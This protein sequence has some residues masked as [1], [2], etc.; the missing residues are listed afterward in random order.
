[1]LGVRPSRVF[2]LV[3]ILAP[4]LSAA[5]WRMYLGDLL[6]TSNNSAE[7]Q[8]T[9]ANISQLQPI[10]KNN[11]GNVISS[12]VT[13]A[14]G[15]L[16]FGDWS[17]N[18]YAMNAAGGSTLWKTFVG[19]APSPSNSGCMPGIGV[20][21]QPVVDTDS[22]YVGGGDS[23]VY[24][25]NRNSG[26]IRWRVPLADANNGGYLWSSVML[27]KSALYIGIAS[28]GD[29][30]LV[31]GGVARI[32]LDNPTHPLIRH[33]VPN[34]T[35]GA[36]VWSTP[37]IDEQANLLYVTTGNGFKQ[38]A[39]T[40]EWGSAL[41]ALDAATLEVKAHFFLP[42]LPTEDD[43]DWGSS[44]GLFQTADGQQYV[45]ANGKNGIMYVLRRPDLT[46]AWQYTLA[47]GCDSPEQGCGSISTP[48]FDG[49]NIVV[50]AGQD[51]DDDGPPGT[52]R[53]FDAA[54]QNPLWVYGARGMVL[55]PVT[56]TPGLVFVP[57][58]KGLAVVDST[59]GDELWTD[60]TGNALYS[61]A[62]V[63]N[64]VV[65][66]TY[67]NGD[68][69]AY[70]VAN[71]GQASTLV[72]TPGAVVFAFTNGGTLPAP[73]PVNVYASTGFLNFNA[74]SDSPWLTVDVSSAATPAVINLQAA[75]S[76]MAPGIYVGKITLSAPG[77]VPPQT[78]AVK[79]VVNGS[80][81][82]MTA[83]N[84]VNSASFQPGALAPGSLFTI[85]AGNLVPQPDSAATDP[86]PTTLSGISVK[87]NGIAVPIA[88]VGPTQ[89][90]GQVPFELAPGPALLVVESNGAVSAPIPLTI[91]ATAPGLF[92]VGKQAAALNQDGSINGPGNPAPTGSI[93]GVYFTGQG[94]VA[95]PPATG[96]S[97]QT[98]SNTLAPT[99]ATIGGLPAIVS[100]SGLAPRF[101]GMG[102]VNVKVPDLAP[103][104][105]PLIL[106]IGDAQSNT[107]IITVRRPTQ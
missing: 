84:V 48:A 38:D 81:P 74:Q 57:T 61:Q 50:G 100:F 99:S 32:P 67:A 103:G 29:C 95:N 77:G 85:F 4:A 98:L 44:P 33:L 66:C 43:P 11:T 78:I 97:S 70:G 12:A 90:N 88:Y 19:K 82:A 79:F 21:S 10:W 35:I 16:Y 72:V 89:V 14:N 6:H 91:A 34:G 30:P 17:G 104:E 68:V 63:A 47:V 105:Y 49:K 42:I 75:V 8:L 7:A 107:G 83:A 45:A 37:A 56:L 13:V 54:T 52:V 18:F 102:Q 28:L 60:G 22:V 80:I 23:M 39:V 93:V 62:A 31:Q 25:L 20:S 53:A 101:I 58:S 64:G 51:E 86:W 92:L 76:G 27:S 46:L 59:T 106:T 55:A 94:Q 2:L 87:I 71:M 15:T 36:S 3:S 24:A 96:A 41:L 40:G 5:D 9:S 69:V 73:Q 26:E 65:Y 1:M